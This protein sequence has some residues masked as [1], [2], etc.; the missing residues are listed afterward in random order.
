M[1]SLR[2]KLLPLLAVLALAACAPAPAAPPE[3]PSPTGTASATPFPPTW[4]T[5]QP[6]ATPSPT[7]LPT[8]AATL[9]PPPAFST[10]LH[11]GVQ[12]VAYISDHC[13]YLAQRWDPRGALPGSV[14]APIMFHSI[15]PGNTAPTD[16]S[17][18]NEVMFEQLVRQAQRLGYETI[19]V[20]Q[21]L[22]FIESNA[23]IP[24]R[25]MILILDDRRP[26]TA[27]D[28]FLPVLEENGWMATLA[29]IAHPDS[30]QR[31][32]RL[33]GEKLWDWIVRLHDTGYF[34]VQ[35]HGL[36]HIYLN[37]SIPIDEV[38]EEI[39]DSIPPLVEHFG[40]AP[41]A[42]IWP[43]GNYTR[44]GLEVAREAGFELGFTVYSRGPIQFNWI[45][46]GEEERSYGEPL[47]LLPRF[48]DTAAVFNLEQTAQ[49]GDAAQQF[50]RENHAAEA[51]WYRQHCG[52]E[53]PPLEDIFKE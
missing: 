42:Y 13:E 10:R 43:G 39:A 51:A 41:V 17:A 37:S 16:P 34:D 33:P 48:W 44:A 46:Q 29:W 8:L 9:P 6:S 31:S 25:S 4:A 23:K 5:A 20:P 49:I 2:P 53:L 35:S 3:P 11:A 1:L 24:P 14:V 21:L 19:T 40:Y 38:R 27:E 22:D 50:A 28:H 36:R 18:I 26:G 45:P 32:G 7:A 12:P 15:L 47:L 52:G 30:A